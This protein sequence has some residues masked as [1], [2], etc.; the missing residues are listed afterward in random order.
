M[1]VVATVSLGLVGLAVQA[2]LLAYFL[3]KMKEHQDSSAVL[4]QVFREFT[5]AAIDALVRRLDTVDEFSQGIRSDRAA[6]LVRLEG[7]ERN[8]EGL[9]VL[10]ETMAGFRATFEAA[11]ER[12]EADAAHI[13]RSLESLQRQMASLASGGG[14]R[15]VQLGAD[16]GE[17]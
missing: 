6:F 11:K 14:G 8:T 1:P 13:A 17:G 16:K 9:Q 7:V 10:R 4:V 3:G 15:L 2:S 12:Q 5:Q